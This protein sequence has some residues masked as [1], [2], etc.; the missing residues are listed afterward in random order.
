MGGGGAAASQTMS[1]VEP[2]MLTYDAS[3][4][5]DRW[6]ALVGFIAGA[7]AIELGQATSEVRPCAQHHP[8]THWAD[9]SARTWAAWRQER[10]R[11][12]TAMLVRFLGP[13][14]REVIDYIDKDWSTEEYSGGCYCGLFLPGHLVDYRGAYGAHAMRRGRSLTRVSPFLVRFVIDGCTG[15]QALRQP[16][17]RVHWASTEAAEEWFGYMEGAM[18][19]GETTAEHVHA[20]LRLASH[21]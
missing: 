21:L 20:A 15:A 5:D 6:G 3:P 14:A 12:V 13:E 16:W 2:L 10:R 1:D 11:R 17:G 8:S 18:A 4:P 9:R 19:S 7:H